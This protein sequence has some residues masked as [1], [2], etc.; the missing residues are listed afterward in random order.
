MIRDALTATL[1]VSALLA[2]VPFHVSARDEGT[3]ATAKLAALRNKVPAFQVIPLSTRAG[4]VVLKRDQSLTIEHLREVDFDDDPPILGQP[5]ESYDT[6]MTD[7]FPPGEAPYVAKSI[8]PFRFRYFNCEFNYGGWHNF[9]MADYASAHGFNILSPYVRSVKQSA[10]LPKRTQWLT[11]GGFINWHEWAR[12]RS[13][14]DGRWDMLAGLDLLKMHLKDE[15]FKRAEQPERLAD[16]GDYLMIDMEHGVLALESLR[17][18][19]WHPK[20]ATDTEKAAFV[21]RRFSQ[22]QRTQASP[23][24]TPF[25]PCQSV[26][27]LPTFE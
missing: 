9:G 8:K 1:T 2:A 11:W 10:H 14:P 5:A 7:D 12:E 19:E 15:R 25:M 21:S 16:M 3:A 26:N 20:D 17:G 13:I 24:R 6:R 4:E 22:E 18:Q 23:T 27:S